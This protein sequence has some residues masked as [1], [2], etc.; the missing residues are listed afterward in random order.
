MKILL[1]F[2]FLNV[3]SASSFAQGY[4]LEPSK[5][6]SQLDIFMFSQMMSESNFFALDQSHLGSI[7]KNDM[8]QIFLDRNNHENFAVL[9]FDLKYLGPQGVIKL[10]ENDYV[11]HGTF[12]SLASPRPFAL[13]T[14]GIDKS[15][16]EKACKDVS[17]SQSFELRKNYVQA[18]FAAALL[19]NSAFASAGSQDDCCNKNENFKSLSAVKNVSS[20]FTSEE[21][22]QKMGTCA[23]DALRGASGVF[24]GAL[25][26]VKSLFTTSPRDLWNGLKA[27]AK[28][29]KR[30]VT[31]LK[32][33]MI[34]LKNAFSNLDADLILAIGCP[35]AGE[36]ITGAGISALTGAGVAM[37]SARV[38]QIMSKMSKLNHLFTKLNKLSRIGNKNFA[39]KVLRCGVK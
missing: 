39:G 37:L 13:F 30:F 27:K 12:D 10:S 9:K 11:C 15:V 3:W 31:N 16:V 7:Y 1:L 4:K 14:T 17:V 38:L 20:F 24:T 23:M 22:M 18:H 21:F 35:L 8:D 34:K 29:I 36:I 28:E 2:A 6:N 32:D 5:E 25:D 26:S 33:E 19:M